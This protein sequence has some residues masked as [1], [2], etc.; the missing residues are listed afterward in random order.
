MTGWL[1]AETAV[2]RLR[3]WRPLDAQQSRMITMQNAGQDASD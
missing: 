3:S 1:T 2:A